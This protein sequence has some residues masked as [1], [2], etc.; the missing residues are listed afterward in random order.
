MV[1]E[2]EN[3]SWSV[4][5]FSISL[6]PSIASMME[7]GFIRFRSFWI[8][9]LR[10]DMKHCRMESGG[11]VVIRLHMVSKEDWYWSTVVVC[12]SLKSVA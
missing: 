7:L 11:K 9:V 6:A 10:P 2:G 5:F 1:R 8:W 3:L 12:F 4:Y